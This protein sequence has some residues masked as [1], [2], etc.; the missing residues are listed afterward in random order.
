[1]VHR[2]PIP[3]APGPERC[4]IIR[5]RSRIPA[6]ASRAGQRRASPPRTT[7]RWDVVGFGR[8]SQVLNRAH[9]AP[10]SGHRRPG[11]A[12]VPLMSGWQLEGIVVWLPD[13]AAV[14]HCSDDV[15]GVI[16][17]V[18]V[19]EVER[20]VYHRARRAGRCDPQEPRKMRLTCR[21]LPVTGSRP[22]STIS[23]HVPGDRSRIPGAFRSSAMRPGSVSSN[24]RC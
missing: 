12:A 18:Q 17:A 3:G 19:V 15:A 6:A 22:D 11:E 1:M 7:S 2:W 16:E 20:S 24:A 4:C 23:S 10:G 9:S 13:L 5:S 8:T 21:R 14:R